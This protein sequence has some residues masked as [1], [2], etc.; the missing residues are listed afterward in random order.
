[1]KK[2]LF[3]LLFLSINFLK[4]QEKK[5]FS[6]FDVGFY[7]GINFYN[8]NN[9]RGDFLVEFKTNLISSLTLKASTGY[10]RTIQPYSNIITVRKYS[11][12]TINDT[13][14]IFLAT[15]YNLVS[16]N[17]DIFPL[18]IG[19]QYDINQS[20]LSPYLSIDVAY[21]IINSSLD[22]SPPEVWSYKSMDEIP[23]EFKGIQKNEILP[24]KSYGIILG[25]GTAYQIS[26]KLNLDIRY[27]FKYD[28]K[29]I[30]THHIIVGIYF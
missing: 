19:I 8:T 9:I 1:M 20:I 7:G 10:F 18:T 26:S 3:V 23:A 12:Y 17:Y 15:K 28:N 24:D 13:S 16:R 4:A 6:S 11:K 14:S 29:I 25:M 22:T 21:N 27:L 5:P 2:I 30:N